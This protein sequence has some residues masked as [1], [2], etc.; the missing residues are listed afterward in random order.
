MKNRDFGSHRPGGKGR[1]GEPPRADRHANWHSRRP[2]PQGPPRG[3]GYQADS[4]TP[5]P[6][7]PDEPAASGES[8][9]PAPSGYRDPSAP[10]PTGVPIVH[11][12][13]AAYGAFI[14]NRMVDH[15]EGGVED[16]KLVAVADRFGRLFGWGF[17]NSRSIIALRMFTHNP[18]RPD[19]TDIDRRIAQAVRLRRD[20]LGI[21]KTT[22]AYRLIHAE[23][24]GLS[25]LIADRFGPYVVIELFSLAM[26]QRTDR[27]EDAIVDAGLNVKNFVLRADEHVMKQEGFSLPKVAA[28]KDRE[29]VITE[30]GVKFNVQLSRGH[31]T[32]F[33]CDQ[34]ENRLAL[35][36]FTPGRQV[37]DVCCYSG[38]FACY[39]A[40]AG[41]AAAVTAVDL[42]EQ[43]LAT[44]R[45]NAALNRASIDFHHADAFEFLRAAARSGRTWPVVVVDPSKFVPRRDMMEIGLRKYADLNRLAASVV[46]PGGILL[47]CS[48]SGLV[49]LPTFLQTVGRAAR[50][51]GR[52]LQ[53]FRTTGA[54]PDHPV[55]AEC[56]RKRLPQGPLD[57]RPLNCVLPGITDDCLENRRGK[58]GHSTRRGG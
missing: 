46:A 23:G 18:Q 56:A 28:A 32:G 2:P 52:D 3:L 42:D 31:K 50:S 36:H 4:P 40:T 7:P 58:R 10:L 17:Y 13:S 27:I 29:V 45:A 43:A 5:D 21:E 12:K 49:D 20:M 34:R 41:R 25:G 11:L 57:T 44:A 37:L 9:A 33:F 19:E 6:A 15:V 51:V 1:R 14:Y 55:M 39:A 54:A 24:D 26:F 48:C 47:T 22:D 35:T 30:N 8:A 38:G 53:V 16:G